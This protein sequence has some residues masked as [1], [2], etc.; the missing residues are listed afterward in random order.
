MS[1]VILGCESPQVVVLANRAQARLTAR[2]ASVNVMTPYED[3]AHTMQNVQARYSAAQP[4]VKRPVLSWTEQREQTLRAMGA[5]AL[6]VITE[7]RFLTD[8]ELAVMELAAK[9]GRNQ[10]ETYQEICLPY[11]LASYQTSSRM[12]GRVEDLG[13]IPVTAS[14]Q[15]GHADPRELFAPQPHEVDRAIWPDEHTRIHQEQGEQ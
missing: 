3:Y 15:F 13:V 7:G 14:E 10:P 1:R 9:L 11:P 5:S 6:L 4:E 8:R 2:G 12:M